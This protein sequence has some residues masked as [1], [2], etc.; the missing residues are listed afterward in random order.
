MFEQYEDE[1]L[2][3]AADG[4]LEHDLGWLLPCV[5]E[6]VTRVLEKE[7]EDIQREIRS[8]HKQAAF[9]EIVPDSS[10][11]TKSALASMSTLSR[12]AEHTQV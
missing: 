8:K 12:R 10:Q 9:I 6:D 4:T 11:T 3:S 5:A 2:R 7:V 1:F